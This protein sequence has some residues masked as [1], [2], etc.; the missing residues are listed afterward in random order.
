MSAL[1]PKIDEAA[2][3]FRYVLNPDALTQ[4]RKLER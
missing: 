1:L 2:P 3:A 4:D